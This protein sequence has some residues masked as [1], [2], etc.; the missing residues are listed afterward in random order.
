MTE[1]RDI[2]AKQLHLQENNQQTE[3]ESFLLSSTVD[4]DRCESNFFWPES[5]LR[6]F[7]S[8]SCTSAAT[9]PSSCC[10]QLTLIFFDLL[11]WSSPKIH[12][13]S[14]EFSRVRVRWIKMAYSD[15]PCS[16]TPRP[17]SDLQ[18]A[19]LWQK[20]NGRQQIDCKLSRT[21]FSNQ[22]IFKLREHLFAQS[23]VN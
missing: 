2:P 8:S 17:R 19:E 5:S 4:D 7:S 20:N 1:Q 16:L 3:D 11:P 12:I 18:R 9:P 23:H 14:D 21:L 22:C 6:L 10:S 13:T 15:W